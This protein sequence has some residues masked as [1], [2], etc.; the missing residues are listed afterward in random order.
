MLHDILL[1]EYEH[2]ENAL[3][4]IEN[5]DVLKKEKYIIGVSGESGTGKSELSYEIGKELNRVGV[6]SK[7]IHLDNYYKMPDP[8]RS[9]YRKRTNFEF[10]G[11][12]EYDW[13]KILYSVKGFIA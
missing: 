9:D 3:A 2:V 4:I 13:Q 11:K 8:E 10:V 1:L 7:I 12:N 5:S 6:L